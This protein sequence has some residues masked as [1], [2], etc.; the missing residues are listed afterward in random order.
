MRASQWI[1]GASSLI[2][3]CIAGFAQIAG[4]Q[5]L[6]VPIPQNAAEVSAPALGPMT[7]SYV[8]AVGRMAY[9]WGWP[10]VYVYNQRNE[11]TKVPEALLLDNAVCVA[12]INQLA[13]LTDYANPAEKLI[14]DPNQ[15]VVYGLGFLSFEKEP[16]VLQV[17]D[18]G[19]RFWTLPIYD[20]RTDEIDQL[21]LPYGTRP[22]FYMIVGPNWKGE[23][24]SGIAGVVR[25][26]TDFAAIMPRIFMNVPQKIMR[27]S[28]PCSTRLR[29]T[30]L[31][32]STER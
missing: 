25:S 12:P 19:E 32:S 20:A 13:M 8:Q 14:A 1:T 7:P 21:G 29:S 16:V 30:H 6:Q 28:S 9:V 10:L 4:A 18:F 2:L 15:D 31:A 23:I 26:S 24:P 3:V 22:G 11:L 5:G 17:P 27:P